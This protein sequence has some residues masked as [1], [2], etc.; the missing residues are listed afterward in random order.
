MPNTCP[1]CGGDVTAVYGFR[2]PNEDKIVMGWFCL[3]DLL[4]IEENHDGRSEE[5]RFVKCTKG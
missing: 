2:P 3:P 5:V 1:K 4:Y